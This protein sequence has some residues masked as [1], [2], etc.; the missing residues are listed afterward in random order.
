MMRKLLVSAMLLTV[1][2]SAITAR[3]QT[4]HGKHSAHYAKSD[5]S[6]A[7]PTKGHDNKKKDHHGNRWQSSQGN[8]R[9]SQRIFYRSQ[10]LITWHDY[11]RYDFNRPDPRY[12]NYYADRYYRDSNYYRPFTLSRDDRIYRGSN[13]R[14]YCRRNDGTTGLIIVGAIAGGLLGDASAPRGSKTV[15]AILGGAG[16]GLINRAIGRDGVRC[17]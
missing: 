9:N 6:N 17:Q 7:L 15:G 13:N 4:G 5:G 14:Y 3:A 2:A 11:N 8:N 12:G 16:A 10:N 1:M